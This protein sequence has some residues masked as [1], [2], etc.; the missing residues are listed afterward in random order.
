MVRT[1]SGIVYR[2]F[3]GGGDAP[4]RAAAA[5]RPDEASAAATAFAR[6]TTAPAP[7]AVFSAGARCLPR[8]QGPGRLG[9]RNPGHRGEG[10]RPVPVLSAETAAEPLPAPVAGAAAVQLPAGT[11]VLGG[12]DAAEAS[13]SG[14]FMLD[15]HGE[16]HAE[17]ALSAPLHDAAASTVGGHVLVFGG[18]TANS[19]DVVQELPASIGAGSNAQVT[20]TVVGHLPR[21]RSDLSAVTVGDHAYVLGGY[22]GTQLDSSVLATADGVSFEQVA[23][24]SGAGPLS[25]RGRARRPRFSPLEERPAKAKPRRRSR[26]STP[27]VAAPTSSAA[28]RARSRTP[29]QWCS[30]ARSTWSEARAPPA[31]RPTRPGASIQPA[32]G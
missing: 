13:V 29:R 4:G 20:A 23:E 3:T 6:T 10:R 12:L 30:A 1:F 5:G 26:K 32:V 21:P 24:L 2:R 18:G 8:G 28:C 15:R 14:V 27:T 7:A 31:N 11:L 16:L 9:I 25:G 19:S 22:D 17:G